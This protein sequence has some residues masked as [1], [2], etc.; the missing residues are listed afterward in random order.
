MASASSNSSSSNNAFDDVIDDNSQDTQDS[1]LTPEEGPSGTAAP[2]AS[3]DQPVPMIY[4]CA[5][6]WHEEE[7]EM[8]ALFKSIF[9]MDKDQCI[10]RL[11][12]ETF[13]TNDPDYYE[14]EGLLTS[15]LTCNYAHQPGGEVT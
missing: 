11:A 6:M 3:E 9:R 15:T 7:D 2:S 5:T 4:A 10:R 14:F 13:K 12:K 8:K 1:N